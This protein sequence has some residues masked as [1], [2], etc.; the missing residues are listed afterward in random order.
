VTVVQFLLVDRGGAGW[1][2]A[3]SAVRRI[4]QA[5]GT[6]VLELPGGEVAADRVT[7]LAWLSPQPPGEVLSKKW[8]VHCA[9]IALSVHGPVVVVDPQRPPDVLRWRDAEGGNV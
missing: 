3:S 6:I 1:A 8:P 2:V 7:G 5:G 4:R 9:G